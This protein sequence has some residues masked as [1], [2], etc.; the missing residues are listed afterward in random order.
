M[1]Y[2][3]KLYQDRKAPLIIA[4]GGGIEWLSGGSTEAD[5]IATLLKMMGV[6]KAAIIEEPDSLNPHSAG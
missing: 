5:D 3:A 2:E 1:I 4:S 6:P